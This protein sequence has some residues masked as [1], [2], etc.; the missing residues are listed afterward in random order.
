M[1]GVARGNQYKYSSGVRN[2]LHVVTV[3]APLTR[4]QVMSAGVASSYEL[5]ISA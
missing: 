4:P 5:D 1:V 2:P 3:P